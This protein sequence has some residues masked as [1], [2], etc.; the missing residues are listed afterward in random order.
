M[1]L[2]PLTRGMCAIVDDE[3]FDWLSKFKWLA[4]PQYPSRRCFY[5]KRDS[6]SKKISMAREIAKTPKG[7]YCDHIN[8]NTLDNRRANLRNCTST[9]NARNASVRVGKAV[10]YKGVTLRKDSGLYRARIRVDGKL[11]NLGSFQTAIEASVAYESAA[12]TYFG[13]FSKTKSMKIAM[14]EGL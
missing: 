8:G 2:I 11:I 5:A 4:D 1:K 13:D 14:V 3:D 10:P 7:L 12:A 9:E 6:R